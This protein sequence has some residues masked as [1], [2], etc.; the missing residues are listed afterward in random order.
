MVIRLSAS[1]DVDHLSVRTEHPDFFAVF[2]K[3]EA[4]SVRLLAVGVVHSQ[5]G[6]PDWGFF[7]ND[8][9]CFSFVRVGAGVLFHHI[10]AVHQR[11]LVVEHTQDGSAFAF[12]AAREHN[13]VVAF[14][15]LLH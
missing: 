1:A 4:D 10:D 15:K 13:N 12:I 9:T 5:I 11:S 3:L 7:L 8:P 14:S 2:K 6:D